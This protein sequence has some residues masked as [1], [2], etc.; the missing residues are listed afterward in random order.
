MLS[1]YKK[2]KASYI[3]CT[4]LKKSCSIARFAGN[5]VSTSVKNEISIKK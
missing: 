3:D 5:Y 2:R 1:E 4:L